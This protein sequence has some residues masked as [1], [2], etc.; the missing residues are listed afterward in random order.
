MMSFF[1]MFLFMKKGL[2][3]EDWVYVC[4]FEIWGLMIIL[5]LIEGIIVW[6]YLFNEVVLLR[7]FMKYYFIVIYLF[8][9]YGFFY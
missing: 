9:Y 1:L 2:Y 4:Q 3:S 8:C 7:I 5:G 6:V